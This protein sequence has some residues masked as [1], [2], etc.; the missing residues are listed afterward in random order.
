[1]ELSGFLDISVA[2]AALLPSMAM[3]LAFFIW[4]ATATTEEE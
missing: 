3:F 4:V 1:M 2:L